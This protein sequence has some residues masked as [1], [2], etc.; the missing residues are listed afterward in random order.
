MAL[1]SSGQISFSNIINEFGQPPGKNLGAYRISE[2]VGGLSNLGLDNN[3]SLNATI[4]QSGTIKFSD[5]YGKKLNIIVN[6]Y[7][8]G[9][10]TRPQNGYQ[11]YQANKVRVLGGFR[12][13]PS[14]P[15]GKKVYIHVNKKLRGEREDNI[16]RCTLKTGQSWNGAELR[17]DVG[18]NGKIFGAGGTGGR[19]H[20]GG[21]SDSRAE[22]G[23]DGTSA[24]G[25]TY[26]AKVKVLS[27]GMILGGG[28]GGGQSKGPGGPGG[29]GF[30]V[31][32]RKFQ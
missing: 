22:S 30:L 23:K 8:G 19:G 3:D 13:R 21:R 26:S 2:N 15:N 16:E 18:G 25:L 6:Y 7:S 29:S 9:T 14:N 32:K 5:F 1:Q 4:P 10:E 11:R 17:V 20:Q 12:G 28:G 27:G 24:L 31:I